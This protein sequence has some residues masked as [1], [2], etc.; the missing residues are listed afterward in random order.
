MKVSSVKKRLHSVVVFIHVLLF[1]NHVYF[2][3][4]GKMMIFM[5]HSKKSEKNPWILLSF[6]LSIEVPINGVWSKWSEWSFCTKSM[7][8]IQTRNRDCVNPKPKYG[9]DPCHGSRVVVR[10]C[11][12]TQTCLKRKPIM[13]LLFFSAIYCKAYLFC[14][15]Y[16]IGSCRGFIG[17]E[18]SNTH[19]E[20]ASYIN[21]AKHKSEVSFFLL[22]F[23][24]NFK[25]IILNPL[26]RN[27]EIYT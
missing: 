6:V 9:G 17:E 13:I 18:T 4:D 2:S 10:K 3:E 22:L 26:Q 25:R 12:N 15:E 19:I 5:I 14:L 21:L 20:N 11:G 23:T 7:D 1:F 8:G 27:P 16:C 24:S